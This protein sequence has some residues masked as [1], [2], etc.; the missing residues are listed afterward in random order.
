M[1]AEYAVLDILPVTL[2][3][4]LCT[5]AVLFW[6]V[7]ML[8]RFRGKI[9]DS[10]D[11]C[12]ANGG[13]AEV[14]QE[15]PLSRLSRNESKQCQ[16][17][18]YCPQCEVP[19]YTKEQPQDDNSGQQSRD[20]ATSNKST[21]S[22]EDNV[23]ERI[24]NVV[25]NVVEKVPDILLS[26]EVFNFEHKMHC[27]VRQI[28]PSLSEGRLKE[29]NKVKEITVLTYGDDHY[30]VPTTFLYQLFLFTF[31]MLALTVQVCIS[32]Y[33]FLKS[34]GCS[35]EPYVHCFEA[36]NH[37]LIIG[38]EELDCTDS[39]ATENI[40][41]VIC[42]DLTLN[43]KNAILEGGTVLALGAL[44]FTL[45]KWVLMRVLY[46]KFWKK[47]SK[48]AMFIGILSIQLIVMFVALC[49]V[50]ARIISLAY[51]QDTVYEDFVYL[52]INTYAVIGGGLVPW[53][54]FKRVIL[55]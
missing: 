49:I 37:F 13:P 23:V 7:M 54:K 15:R 27:L 33:L 44:Y 42:Y 29:G 3:G 50:N 21:H 40:T 47:R 32:S 48:K 22:D 10:S 17:N 43:A 18:K 2:A 51:D 45:I 24:R 26:D 28:F 34:Y 55:K 52:I 5:L 12:E 36:R 1:G 25:E 16:C 9:K 20:D 38:T 41:S 53:W 31:V 35:T 4:V 46:M 6:I 19:I 39:K 14:L 11:D 30:Y 8:W